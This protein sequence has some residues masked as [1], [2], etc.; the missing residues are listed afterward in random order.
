MWALG[1]VVL[2]TSRILRDS[3]RYGSRLALLLAMLG[4]ASVYDQ[5]GS[6]V[7][8]VATWTA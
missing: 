1:Q 3:A 8:H 7:F 5:C 6:P 4:G 2:K